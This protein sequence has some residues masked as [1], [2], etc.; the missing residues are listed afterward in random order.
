MKSRRENKHCKYNNKHPSLFSVVSSISHKTRSRAIGF[1]PAKRGY[2]M[3][4]EY[5]PEDRKKIEHLYRDGL[6]L[7]PDFSCYLD[8]HYKPFVYEEDGKI[9]G[10]I[11]LHRD[12][13]MID[14][15]T[16]YVDSDHRRK[17]IGRT[18]LD[19]AE[20]YAR[21]RKL[22]GVKLEG[23]FGKKTERFLSKCGYQ[24]VGEVLNSRVKDEASIFYWK[25]TT[26][27]SNEKAIGNEKLN[28]INIW[29]LRK[30]RPILNPRQI[31]Y[32]QLQLRKKI[33]YFR[34]EAK[35]QKFRETMENN[36]KAVQEIIKSL[37]EAME[38]N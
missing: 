12:Y 27:D 33:E 3:I 36:I 18:L 1:Y 6:F 23:G 22:H 24:R 21:K 7:E 15:F 25:G 31:G 26:T 13:F 29:D 16:L 4:R 11:V 2:P 10:V 38:E 35:D 20:E 19:F 28:G 37:D 32:I 30:C 9:M 17:G 34:R 8:K 14:V 5:T